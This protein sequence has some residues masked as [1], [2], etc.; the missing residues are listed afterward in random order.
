MNNYGKRPVIRQLVEAIGISAALMIMAVYA[1]KPEIVAASLAADRVKMLSAQ[2]AA[3]IGTRT[4]NAKFDAWRLRPSLDAPSTSH[5]RA[6][7]STSA[8]ANEEE[9]RFECLL[10][11]QRNSCVPAPAKLPGILMLAQPWA[12]PGTKS[13]A[14]DFPGIPILLSSTGSSQTAKRLA[15]LAP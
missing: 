1:R 3:L 5:L 6:E 2:S 7:L 11:C 12:G 8:Q 15:S 13:N 9:S 10:D 14:L 4:S